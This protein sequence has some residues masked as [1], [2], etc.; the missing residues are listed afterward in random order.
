MMY[1]QIWVFV[2]IVSVFF[3]QIE[4]SSRNLKNIEN[5]V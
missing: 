5:T 2:I 3:F 1:K 4:W